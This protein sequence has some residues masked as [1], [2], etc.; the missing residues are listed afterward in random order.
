MKSLNQARAIEPL[1]VCDDHPSDAGLIHAGDRSGG[2]NSDHGRSWHAACGNEG[3]ASRLAEDAMS[4][5][6]WPNVVDLGVSQQK[7]ERDDTIFSRQ[8]TRG[9]GARLVGRIAT[10]NYASFSAAK[11]TLP[12]QASPLSS[13]FASPNRWSQFRCGGSYSPLANQS[14]HSSQQG[15][16][17]PEFN[18]LGSIFQSVTQQRTNRIP[19]IAARMGTEGMHALVDLAHAA[20]VLRKL[21]GI[22]LISEK[23]P[24]LIMNPSRAEY[25]YRES[26][27]SAK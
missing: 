9:S 20:A 16:A 13:R 4:G 26:S 15:P 14:R 22:H 18:S 23:S 21:I 7:G 8:V 24:S 5:F 2:I 12:M 10:S 27:L 25:S 3:L 19:F 17:G 11:D 1:P 6:G